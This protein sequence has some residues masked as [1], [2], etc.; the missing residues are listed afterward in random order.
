VDENAA[1]A[2]STNVGVAGGG[3]I[4]REQIG[5]LNMPSNMVEILHNAKKE[6]ENEKSMFYFTYIY[7]FLSC[8]LYG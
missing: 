1:Q 3:A 4:L 7:G 5:H 2:S 6:L 8:S